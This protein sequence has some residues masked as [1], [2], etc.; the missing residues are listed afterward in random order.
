M[1]LV[2]CLLLFAI[3]VNGTVS[4]PLK[5]SA[6]HRY[7][8]DQ[9]NVPFLVV[10][11]SP[12]SLIVKLN[13][14]DQTTYFADRQ[15]K[16]FNA[17]LID[18]LCATYTGGGTDGTAA[19]I[20]PFTTGT[21]P[22]SYDLATPNETYFALVDAALSRAAAV[23]IVVFLDPI[24][25]GSWTTTLAN[26]GST[27]AT[28]YGAFL[29]NRYK[30]TTNIVWFHG[31]DFS[32]GCCPLNSTNNNLVGNVIDGI[33]SVDTN[34][35]HT[36]LLGRT[37]FATNSDVYSNLDTVL[38]SKFG[39]NAAYTFSSTVNV[40]L[41][42]YNS[43]PTTPVFLGE[44]NY[45]FENILG[46]AGGATGTRRLRAE[47]YG[48]LTFGSIGGILYGNTFTTLSTWPSDQAARL[49][50]PGAAEI[51]HINT[52]FN[53]IAWWNLVPDQTHAVRSEER[54]VGKECRL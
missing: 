35:L 17:V 51:A 22:A 27:K 14:T 29:G 8:I 16:G 25:T 39:A 26:N 9:N 18:V 21:D 23:G 42:A 41:N 45:E 49:D 47:N 1:R 44:A 3:T 15:S 34:H 20:K 7:F 52:L 10:G 54:R 11:D 53:Q 2:L 13:S 5:Q 6:N 28:N 12:Q 32:D 31:N 50:T 36:I 38:S 30:N 33:Q 37:D 24:E 4:Y 19:G 40:T 43:T 46:Y 48:A